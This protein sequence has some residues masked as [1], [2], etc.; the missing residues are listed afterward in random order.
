MDLGYDFETD[1][2]QTLF[3]LFNFFLGERGDGD[4]KSGS[5]PG[6]PK[7]KTTRLGK[8]LL[9]REG[10]GWILARIEAQQIL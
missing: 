1:L 5:S 7:P 9:I 2:F 10:T 4:L 3:K 6:A 8:A